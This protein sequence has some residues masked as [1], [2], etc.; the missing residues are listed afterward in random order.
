MLTF[1][2][3]LQGAFVPPNKLKTD[4]KLLNGIRLV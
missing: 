1:P 4:V 3:R 2:S